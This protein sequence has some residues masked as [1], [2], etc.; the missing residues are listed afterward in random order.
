MKTSKS[1]KSLVTA[2]QEWIA[3]TPLT[4][5]PAEQTDATLVETWAA[6][7]ALV[8][9]LDSARKALREELL[10]RAQEHGEPTPKGGNRWA[11]GESEVLRE[12]RRASLPDEDAVRS[13]LAARGLAFDAAFSPVTKVVLDASKVEA[14][15]SLGR[16]PAA[17]IEAA[18]KV[19]WALRVK[20]AEGMVALVESLNG[21]KTEET[22]KAKTAKKSKKD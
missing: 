19:T 13:M 2:I 22:P 21:P 7:D 12:C 8:E 3:E 10:Q 1:F 6:L 14:L 18:R 11:V 15:V 20:P 4:R 16:L 9:R 5:V 17:E